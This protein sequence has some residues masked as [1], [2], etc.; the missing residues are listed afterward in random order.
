MKISVLAIFI[1]ASVFFSASAF[2]SS[3]EGL[4]EI[5]GTNG[6]NEYR[7]E[8]EIIDHEDAFEVNWIF[9]GEEYYIGV[10]VLVGDYLAV[11]YT[12]EN[13]TDMGVVIYRV[14]SNY[15]TGYWATWAGLRGYENAYKNGLPS[16]GYDEIYTLRA[17]SDTPAKSYSVE[18]TNPDGSD[19]TCG[20]QIEKMDDV[21]SISWI[22][23][24]FSY[25]GIAVADGNLF[26]CCWT[27]ES[28]NT[29]GV[30]LMKLS[31]S[32]YEGTWAFYGSDG[33]GSEYWEKN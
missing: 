16:S 22:F 10:G 2:A 21:Y 32:D 3:I 30:S 6:D 19:Y 4:Y 8:L 33:R 29:L 5:W 13:N 20:L 11:S 1:A 18:G 14:G 28:F 15:L 17:P 26:V 12:D 24:D 23:E 9:G 7:G 31:G 25:D 27:D